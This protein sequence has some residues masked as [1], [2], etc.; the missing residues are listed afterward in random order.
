MVGGVYI[1]TGLSAHLD[2]AEGPRDGL[3]TARFEGR[4]WG[5]C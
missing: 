3:R 4:R 5:G 1:V 2:R